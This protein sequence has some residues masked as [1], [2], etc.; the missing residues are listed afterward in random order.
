MPPT[1]YKVFAEFCNRHGVGSYA[2][3]FFDRGMRLDSFHKLTVIDIR[4]LRITN[5]ALVKKL[6][7]AASRAPRR[8]PRVP[9]KPRQARQPRPPP[10]EPLPDAGDQPTGRQHA[11]GLR[12]PEVRGSPVS[13]EASAEEDEEVEEAEE[14][15]VEVVDAGQV[16][17]PT[18]SA[19][20]FAKVGG[21]VLNPTANQCVRNAMVYAP[22]SAAKRER[23]LDSMRSVRYNVWAGA[24]TAGSAVDGVP[25]DHGHGGQAHRCTVCAE[26]NIASVEI[27]D[28]LRAARREEYPFPRCCS[29]DPH[30][31]TPDYDY[32]MHFRVLQL[33][34]DVCDTQQSITTEEVVARDALMACMREHEEAVFARQ[35]LRVEDEEEEVRKGGLRAEVAAWRDILSVAIGDS[36]E[37]NEGGR[38]KYYTKLQIEQ[39]LC[40]SHV[41]EYERAC[42]VAE[43]DAGVLFLLEVGAHLQQLAKRERKARKAELD[44]LDYRSRCPVC[45]TRNCDFFHHPWRPWASGRDVMV[46]GAR[47]S[48]QASAGIDRKGS[49]FK[50]HMLPTKQNMKVLT[51]RCHGISIVSEYERLEMHAKNLPAVTARRAQALKCQGDS[52]RLLRGPGRTAVAKATYSGASPGRHMHSPT[53]H[54]RRC[55]TPPAVSTPVP[56]A[57]SGPP[58]A[59]RRPVLRGVDPTPP[60]QLQAASVDTA[61]RPPPVFVTQADG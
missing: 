21:K 43:E 46:G 19:S 47:S 29:H 18:G 26:L 28:R 14:A 15:D 7:L 1:Q 54:S 32:A 58:P 48:N 60:H 23:I 10:P 33:H 44:A 35:R 61:T 25:Q 53:R 20:P 11:G 45:W 59:A 6:L 51:G 2:D 36:F 55:L 34:L 42:V 3:L 52:Q 41:E 30:Y 8:Q 27:G 22:P 49:F 50:G 31:P 13:S 37:L 5:S 12:T 17:S 16:A 9:H 24:T 57:P 56:S 39:C 38:K 4:R 40:L